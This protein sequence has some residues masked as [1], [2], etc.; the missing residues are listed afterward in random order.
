MYHN[1]Q[2]LIILY[3]KL[4]IKSYIPNNKYVTLNVYFVCVNCIN[5]ILNNVLFSSLC[6]LSTCIAIVRY[7]W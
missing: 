7:T 5:Y 4:F 2:K 6:E 1:I 3:H